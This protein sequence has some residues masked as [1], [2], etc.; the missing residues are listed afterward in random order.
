MSDGT[1]WQFAGE[2][3]MKAALVAGATSFRTG[4]RMIEIAAKQGPSLIAGASSTARATEKDDIEKAQAQLREAMVTM[5]R[6]IAEASWQ[7][8]RRG[9]D[10]F[11]AMTRPDDDGDHRRP[12]R[13]KP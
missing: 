10:D 11:D 13:V 8:A 4:L 12:W 5:A 7:E 6:E 3:A 9:V 1:D 2:L